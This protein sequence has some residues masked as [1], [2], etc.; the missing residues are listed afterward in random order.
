MIDYFNFVV[1]VVK[2]KESAGSLR[3]PNTKL[4]D[5]FSTQQCMTISHN[6]IATVM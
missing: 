1:V 2:G 4:W 5:V 6:D 3:V